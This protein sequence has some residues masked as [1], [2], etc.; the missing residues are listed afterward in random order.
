MDFIFNPILTYK[1][2]EFQT[3]RSLEKRL[4]IKKLPEKLR[5]SMKNSGLGLGNW[6]KLRRKMGFN[7]EKNGAKSPKIHGGETHEGE[8]G[9][10]KC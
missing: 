6:Q 4:S 5:I 8:H 2:L 10:E 9:G 1:D 7:S 3:Q